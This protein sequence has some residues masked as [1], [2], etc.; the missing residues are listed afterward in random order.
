MT[1]K[2]SFD[3]NIYVFFIAFIIGMFY[4]YISSPK[5]KVIIKYPTPYNAEK[6]VYQNESENCY[7]FDVEEI[8]CDGKTIE[9]PIV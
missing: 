6:T 8:K 1:D 2:K 5:A 7:K 3:F 9:Q 4:V